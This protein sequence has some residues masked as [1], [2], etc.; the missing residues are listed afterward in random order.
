[1]A[2]LRPSQ[3][4]VRLAQQPGLL[5]LPFGAG[6]AV[7]SFKGTQHSQLYI[8]KRT[9]SKCQC[10]LSNKSDLGGHY[11][12]ET[13]SQHTQKDFFKFLHLVW[14]VNQNQEY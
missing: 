3:L 5:L 10:T 9:K 8:D 13:H 12:T 14:K 1:M 4:W 7:R 11:H 2:A 6:L